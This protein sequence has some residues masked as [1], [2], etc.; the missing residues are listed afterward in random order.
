MK[1]LSIDIGV[2]NMAFFCEEFNEE[3]IKKICEN[4]EGKGNSKIKKTEKRFDDNCIAIGNYKKL[5]DEISSTGNCIFVDKL[6]LS[7]KKGTE[8][9]LQI[10]INL[11]MFFDKNK[12]LIDTI[13]K[14][15]IEQQVK[16]NPMAQR[17]E[18]HCVSWFTFQYLNTK[19]IIIFPA[20][21]KYLVLGAP[22]NKFDEKKNTVR[23][24]NKNER[25]K[26]ACDVVLTL[27]TN[28]QN[29]IYDTNNTN[30]TNTSIINSKQLLEFIFDKNSNKKDDISDTICQL[31]AFKIKR[32]LD[33]KI[34]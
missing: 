3:D 23:K 26:W 20:R 2:H 7:H 8:F 6:D 18:Q 17:I 29:S 34:K 13:D 4:Y 28:K 32:F 24:L 31:N 19:E 11:T 9:D 14:V 22:K 1:I 33:K 15:V 5:V 16:T 12:K 10:F 21:N 27:L 30:N 25:K